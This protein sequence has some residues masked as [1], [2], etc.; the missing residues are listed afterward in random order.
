MLGDAGRGIRR[1]VREPRR[2]VA[3]GHDHDRV[4]QRALPAKHGDH[5]GHRRRALADRA[6]HADDVAVALI[7]DG[8]DRDRGLAG[9]PIAEDQLA[10]AAADRDQRIDHLQAGLQRHGHR[11]SIHDRRRRAFDRQAAATDQGPVS[12]ERIAERVDHAAEPAVAY[13][14]VHHA[15]DPRGLVTGSQVCMVA[16]QHHADLVF[17]DVERDP[18]DIAGKADR[19]RVSDARQTADACDAG[20]DRQDRADLACDEPGEEARARPFD[21]GERAVVRLLQR[22][23]KRAHA[24]IGAVAAGTDV[25]LDPGASSGTST[26]CSRSSTPRSSDAR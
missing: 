9:L 25:A 23:G 19:F 21:V 14:D 12:V 18:R 13:R 11:R 8:I 3:L 16:K 4:S 22:V 10:L 20:R 26:G 24:A 2:V 6:V 7:D 1:D 17:V 15:P 5:L